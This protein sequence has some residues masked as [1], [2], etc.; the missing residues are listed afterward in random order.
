[1]AINISK[2][3]EKFTLKEGVPNEPHIADWKGRS[4]R[5]ASDVMLSVRHPI[6]NGN[7]TSHDAQLPH[8]TYI[9]MKKLSFWEIGANNVG[10]CILPLFTSAKIR[11]SINSCKAFL[12]L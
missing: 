12:Q 2:K 1:V 9:E 4:V 3:N 10:I 7:Y 11:G 6:K 8:R 5:G